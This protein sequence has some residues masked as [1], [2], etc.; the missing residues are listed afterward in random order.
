MEFSWRVISLLKFEMQ[1]PT[2]LQAPLVGTFLREGKRRRC[3]DSRFLLRAFGLP[4]AL[5]QNASH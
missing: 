3:W 2:V 5:S 1:N 4:P